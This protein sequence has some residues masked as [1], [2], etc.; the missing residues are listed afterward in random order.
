MFILG[1]FRKNDPCG[2]KMVTWI[3]RRTLTFCSW[4]ENT[5]GD[6]TAWT[7]H[8]IDSNF[9]GGR[10]AYAADVDG[11]RDLDVIGTASDDYKIAWWKNQR[12]ALVS[13][14]NFN[15]DVD[16]NDFSIIASEWLLG[17]E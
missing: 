13:D 4:W 17:V 12:A 14:F 10:S 1:Y 5:A 6:G 9:D 15:G 3:Y 11:D 8:Y 7:E 2:D 16:L